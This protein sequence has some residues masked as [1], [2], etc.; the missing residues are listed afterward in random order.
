RGL[1]RRTRPRPVPLFDRLSGHALR[2]AAGRSLDAAALNRLQQHRRPAIKNGTPR[3]CPVKRPLHKGGEGEKREANDRVC[4]I[5]RQ[6][7]YTRLRRSAAYWF[8]LSMQESE[9]VCIASRGG[10][11]PCSAARSFLSAAASIWRTRSAEM[12]N[13]DASSV[14]VMPPSSCNQRA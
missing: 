14:S 6:T 1:L 13:S 5:T 9:T 7:L 10:Y 8:T 3:G 12:P 11:Q 4:A 2:C